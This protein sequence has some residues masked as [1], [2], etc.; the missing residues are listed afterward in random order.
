[1]KLAATALS[2]KSG[3]SAES[4]RIDGGLRTHGEEVLPLEQHGT[5]T[6]LH[7]EGGFS[8]DLST[9]PKQPL[10]TTPSTTTFVA[11]VSGGSG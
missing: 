4:I 2:I 6:S 8:S 9:W 3:G 11:G 10:P 1:M 7:I 5:I